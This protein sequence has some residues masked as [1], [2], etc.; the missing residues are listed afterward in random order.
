MIGRTG[1]GLGLSAVL[2]QP[3]EHVLDV[4]D[5][6]VDQLADGDG[7]AAEVSSC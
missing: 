7:E 2:A 3:P 5:G 6:I 1:S 4:D